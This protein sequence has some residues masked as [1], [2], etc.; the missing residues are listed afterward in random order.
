MLDFRVSFC[1][2]IGMSYAQEFLW[3]QQNIGEIAGIV[4]FLLVVFFQFLKA[5]FDQR[6]AMALEKQ[7]REAAESEPVDEL[8][9]TDYNEQ[10]RELATP[11]QSEVVR[12]R[13]RPR[14]KASGA[15][16]T[17]EG[18]S[19]RRTL[20]R[21]LAPQGESAR[22]DAAPGTLD[23]DRIVAPSVEPTVK[24]TLESMTGIY[25]ATPTVTELGDQPL[26][27]DIQKL[28]ARPEGIRQAIILAEILRRPES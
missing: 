26:T 25:E 27:L 22:F 11:K 12:Q 5:V 1:D 24:P 3:G 16:E 13:K 18:R 28:I 15:E 19:K 10:N 23:A 8:V 7:K 2:N 21:E 6:A 14:S 4:V 20:S 17:S 9:Y